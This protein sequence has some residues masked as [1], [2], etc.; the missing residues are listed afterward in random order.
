MSDDRTPPL[1]RR[2]LAPMTLLV[3]YLSLSGALFVL[4][5]KFQGLN[6]VR[7]ILMAGVEPIQRTMQLPQTLYE[8]AKTYTQTLLELQEE[9]HQLKRQ[10][11]EHSLALTEYAQIRSENNR[12][13]ALLNIKQHHQLEGRIAEVLYRPRDPFSRRAIINLGASANIQIGQAAVNANGVLGQ[14]TRV[15]PF[16]SELTLITNKNHMT[17]VKIER[18]GKTLILFGLGDNTLEL[19]FVPPETDIEQDDL[20]ITSGLDSV[21]PSGFP[22]AKIK[23]IDKTGFPFLKIIAHPITSTQKL[24]EILLLPLKEQPP[25]LP[26]DLKEEMLKNPR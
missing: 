18:T 23:H 4:D 3:V 9:N 7:Q 12:L 25:P 17:P 26:S 10:H 19:R 21:Y 1:F 15:F 16:V 8:N 6:I 11:L 24:D 14:I 5:L 22:V 13:R 20:L 2:G